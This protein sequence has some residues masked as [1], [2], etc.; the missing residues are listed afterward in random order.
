MT[1]VSAE[2]QDRGRYSRPAYRW[3]VLFVLTMLYACH[4]MDR[5]LPNILVEPVR[6]E[7]HLNDGQLGLFTG[8]TYGL[9]FSV[10]VLPAGWIADR[11]RRRSFL[12]LALLFWSVLTTAGGW[13]RNY[14]QLLLTRAAVGVAESAAAPIVLPM[15]SDVFPRTRRAFAMGALYMAVPLGALVASS[16]GG[17]VAAGYGWRTAF[18]V[19]GLPG[20][21]I[22]ILL[23]TTVQEPKRGVVD[24]ASS[25]QVL[26]TPNRYTASFVHFW[27]NPGLLWLMLG[28]LIM[29]VLNIIMN[30]WMSSFF[31][32]VHGLSVTQAGLVLG[33]GAGLCGIFSPLIYG[34]LADRLSLRDPRWSL[35]L[36]AIGGL[37][38]LAFSQ[39]QLFTPS[40]TIAIVGFIAADFVR[41]GYS[42]PL[43]AV[44]MRENFPLPIMGTMVG[45]G[46]MASS[47]GMALGPLA[48]GLLFDTYGSYAWLYI[49]SF[50]IGLCAALIMLTFRPTPA[51]QLAAA[52]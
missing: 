28:G 36:V 22:A 51:P 42:P 14:L 17:Y 44:L 27:R 24:E 21:L 23:I 5:A 29:A 10:A 3:Y 38:S 49:G 40:A 48:G 39:L 9:A 20:L 18:F 12:A 46:S 32:R 35:W 50:G 52:A 19:A 15:V 6:N 34:W 37:L 1:A 8:L 41:T 11:V 2:A 16:V 26:K 30:A 25:P 45:A 13:T 47:L 7:F 4:S 43:Y 33:L 31:I